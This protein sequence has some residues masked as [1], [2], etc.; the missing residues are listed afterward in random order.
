MLEFD[1]ETRTASL[2]TPFC[3]TGDVDGD[4]T[5]DWAFG[6]QGHPASMRINLC[7]RADGTSELYSLGPLYKI[8]LS[9]EVY[10]NNYAQHLT[11]LLDKGKE[12]NNRW[13]KDPF[14]HKCKT[15]PNC[16]HGFIYDKKPYTKCPDC[17]QIRKDIEDILNSEDEAHK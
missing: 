13:G 5:I 10:T 12:I 2:P 3:V 14:W 8:K 9:P 1:P 15:N 16:K 11:R 4:L 17:A 6:P 7:F